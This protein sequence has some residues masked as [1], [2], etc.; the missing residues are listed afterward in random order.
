MTEVNILDWII[1]GSI[2][3]FAAICFSQDYDIRAT[4]LQSNNLLDLFTM[5][6][7]LELYQ[8]VLDI[9]KAGG[10]P[11]PDYIASYNYIVYVVVGIL[12][13]PMKLFYAIIGKGINIDITLIYMNVILVAIVLFSGKIFKQLMNKMTI[14]SDAKIIRY[15][16]LSSPILIY[17][18]LQ[19]TQ[20]DII[21]LII[22]L[23]ALTFYLDEK[24]HKFSLI[25]SI[26][27]F[28]KPFPL[29]LFI[30][31]ILICE[32]KLCKLA[33]YGFEAIFPTLLFKCMFLQDEAYQYSVAYAGSRF[34][35]ADKLFSSNI[36]FAHGEANL[37]I[38]SML[39]L[40]FICY[41]ARYEE[42]KKWKYII[43]VPLTV[44]SLF[45]LFVSWHPQ[46]L[47]IITPFIAMAIGISH[48]KKALLIMNTFF[49]I[50]VLMLCIVWT[51][52]CDNFMINHGILPLISKKYYV[53]VS[54]IEIVN[55]FSFAKYYVNIAS[56][57]ISA[58]L[59]CILYTTIMELSKVGKYPLLSQAPIPRGYVYLQFIPLVLF[60]VVAVVLYILL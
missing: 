44:Y 33:L 41:C 21:Y 60:D 20:V 43:M 52:S 6:K 32:K 35:F 22:S 59:I 14:E 46:W 10:Y 53:G 58:S 36:R 54:Y 5:G 31:L 47:C 18:I 45:I 9:V 12:I 49:L 1:W 30:P 37:F 42:E 11:S 39:I 8:Y 29:L 3:V 16:Y 26:A 28:F 27:V 4:V 15:V 56:S 24:F 38:I 2:A 51:P 55:Q 17:G 13:L 50:G 19:F 40:C 25:I 23:Y 34:G 48:K 57:I 7:P